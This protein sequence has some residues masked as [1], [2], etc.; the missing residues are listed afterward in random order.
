MEKDIAENHQSR[1]EDIETRK[2][3]NAAIEQPGKK[4]NDK[5]VGLGPHLSI[6][7]LHVN[8]PDSSVNRHSVA[9]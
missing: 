7:S 9:G 1:R 3:N 6:I 8:R 2:R 5:T 4:K